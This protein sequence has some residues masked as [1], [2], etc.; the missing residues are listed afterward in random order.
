MRLPLGVSPVR[1]ACRHCGGKTMFG[2]RQ[3]HPTR[4]L[5]W[6]LQ[7]FLCTSC[8]AVTLL[9]SGDDAIVVESPLPG[10]D[11][12]AATWTYNFG[13]YTTVLENLAFRIVVYP[14]GSPLAGKYGCYCKAQFIGLAA[15][16]AAAKTACRTHVGDGKALLA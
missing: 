2:G 7:T 4:G 5:P 12:L 1:P 9:Q 10:R 14:Q 15:D 16:L 13:G 3:S 8:S 11:A 6:E